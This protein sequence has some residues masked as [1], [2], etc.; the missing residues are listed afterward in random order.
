MGQTITNDILR[1]VYKE[2]NRLEREI[3]LQEMEYD[4]EM[5]EQFQLFKSVGR[6]LDQLK[7]EPSSACVDFVLAY[8]KRNSKML[9]AC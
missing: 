9:K 8:S 1:L 3:L 4:E 6:E 5:K 2:T 7:K